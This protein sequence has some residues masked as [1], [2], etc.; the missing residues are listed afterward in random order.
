MDL[1]VADTEWSSGDRVLALKEDAYNLGETAADWCL[2][3]T[4]N[5]YYAISFELYKIKNLSIPLHHTELDELS[6]RYAE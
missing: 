2:D 6:E 4:K 1:E 5:Q 3:P